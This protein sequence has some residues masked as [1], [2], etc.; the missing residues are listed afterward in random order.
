MGVFNPTVGMIKNPTYIANRKLFQKLQLV[1]VWTNSRYFPVKLVEYINYS[2]AII[3]IIPYHCTV[4]C[5][6]PDLTWL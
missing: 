2:Y 4:V 5:V 6:V 3:Y 1:K